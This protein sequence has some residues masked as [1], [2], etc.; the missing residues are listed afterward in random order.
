MF[1]KMKSIQ[2]FIL[3]LIFVSAAIILGNRYKEKSLL[4][5]STVQR[6]ESVLHKK[7]LVA[8]KALASLINKLSDK[9][10]KDAITIKFLDNANRKGIEILAYKNDSLIYWSDNNAPFDYKRYKNSKDS[11]RIIQL[12]N[13]Y[14][15]IRKLQNDSVQV[16]ALI[17]IKYDYPYQNE[18]IRNKFYHDL[19]LPQK[20]NIELYENKFNVR[21]VE[22]HFLFSLHR[23]Q[24]GL[25]IEKNKINILF[26]LY[27]IGFLFFIAFIYKIYQR[28]SFIFKNE[29]LLI[30]T[31][32]IDVI[33][34]RFFLYYF[35]IPRILYES[36]LFRSD[37][38]NDSVLLPSIG[39]AFINILLILILLMIIYKSI[40]I[41]KNTPINPII[42]Y[43]LS[44]LFL[45][46][47][48]LCFVYTDT[49]LGKILLD[50]YINITLTNIFNLNFINVLGLL[51]I[52]FILFSLFVIVTKISELIVSLID[53]WKVF[54]ILGLF[55]VVCIISFLWMDICDVY[56]SIIITLIIAFQSFNFM[57]YK[58]PYS[59]G[60]LAVLMVVFSLLT[61]FIIFK[62]NEIKN[63]NNQEL[64]AKNIS[65]KGNKMLELNYSKVKD[66]IENDSS[67][68]YLLKDT[69]S[70]E[71]F[72]RRI[73]KKILNHFSDDYWNKFDLLVT[74]CDSTKILNIQPDDYF[75]NCHG[76][77]NLWI[78]EAG[79]STS[80]RNFFRL[81]DNSINK[82]FIGIINLNIYNEV[83]KL[84]AFIEIYSR[85]VPEGL[86]YPEL[87]MGKGSD[88]D[89]LIKDYSIAKYVE[90]ELV[91]K[92]GNYLYSINKMNYAK[93][94]EIADDFTKNGY[95]HNYY[96]TDTNTSFIVSRKSPGFFDFIA[97]FPYLLILYTIYS[98]V[99][100][101]IVFP[102]SEWKIGTM[103]LRKRLRF[104][105]IILVIASFLLIGIMSIIYIVELN[106]KKI[107]DT[108]GEKSHS[109]LIELEHKLADYESITPE[110]HE[111][112]EG[113]LIKFSQVFFTD[114][115][116]YGIN[117]SLIASSRPQIFEEGLLSKKID[118][119]A[120]AK[121][122]NDKK[123][124]YI[125]RE[126]IGNYEYFSAYLPFRN[127]RN[128]LM[129]LLN[130]PYFAKQD[131]LKN[132][133]STF[134][135]AFINV[136]IIIFAIAIL[137]TIIVSRYITKPLQLLREKIGRVELGKL[138]E[139]I[140]WEHEDEIG[141]LVYEY[142]RMLDELAK[143]AKLL[144]KS[145]RESAWREMAKQVAHEIKNPLTPMKLNVQHL[146]RAWKDKSTDWETQ[147][148]RITKTLIEQIEN[149][150]AIATEFSDFAK[151]P[152]T[153]NEKLELSVLVQDAVDLYKNA[154][155]VEFNIVFDKNESFYI[156]A[157]RK[158]ILRVFNNLFENSI[159]AL[160][161]RKD[162]KI[163]IS[164]IKGKDTNIV[165]V[166][167]NGPGIDVKLKDKIF[168]P[169]FT[170]K[171]SGMGMGLAIVR[172]IVLGTGGDIS[173]ET[174]L[175]K[176]T[177]FTLVFP[178]Y[179]INS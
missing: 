76:Y 149:L 45:F 112:L 24:G 175:N 43:S 67:I 28:F 59:F 10:K 17:L 49:L 56:S 105:I 117:G 37:F 55:S 92:F 150:S 63:E 170:T 138:N 132:E 72:D 134:V 156:Y 75:I 34:I 81:L 111:Y 39:D 82:N 78:E 160:E 15:E 116:L 22:N 127:A 62:N 42:R 44:V 8:D 102:V 25:F 173:F 20:I 93:N 131:E 135:T 79:D 58:K 178:K 65:S 66:E 140:E 106:N 61:T 19:K 124:L 100:L 47:S 103:T 164:I 126:K 41:N 77:F 54:V 159:Q 11:A 95:D 162:G 9:N 38:V 154:K 35:K 13:G 144:A 176:G 29:L 114:I 36:P 74:V 33:I 151:M 53:S 167:D 130:L 68:C 161:G 71:N 96:Q 12:K 27:T 142:N 143:S 136:Y 115:N 60:K 152:K 48:Y 69:L 89:K 90:E 99:F 88:V 94:G 40:R 57:Y 172:S 3:S 157:D 125:Q 97:P 31:F 70:D 16:L 158:Q 64:F 171:S 109:V 18:Y 84:K 148:S 50:S 145:E 21:S 85:F 123:L 26:I 98:L 107:Q 146:K 168:S 165:K 80:I 174:E 52:S 137:I 6:I 147:F 51:V 139:K 119:E 86:G 46:I 163:T 14:Y 153:R 1:L 141:A 104:S 121:L 128:K 166:A 129:A 32:V 133:L 179:N 177:V 4:N 108:L 83:K 23:E 169:S 101:L 155:N 87:L 110:M 2:I 73:A 113:L 122:I 91:Y 118:N 5:N 30:I 120:Y 7:E